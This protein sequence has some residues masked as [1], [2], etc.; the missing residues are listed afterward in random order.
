MEMPC[1]RYTT[2]DLFLHRYQQVTLFGNDDLEMHFN[3]I[4]IQNPT[5]QILS[6]DKRTFELTDGS[7]KLGHLTYEN[8]FSFKAN[9]IVGSDKYEIT[10]T[11]IFSS[12]ISVTKNGIEVANL[13]MNWKGHITILFPHGQEFILK[14]TGIFMDDYALEDKDRQILMFL[15]PDFNWSKFVYNYSISYANKPQDLLLVLLATY[16]ANYCITAASAS[17]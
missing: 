16:A 12:S 17:C 15:D 7:D 2:A 4:S 5:M 8:L 13:N 1:D 14:A 3:E 11:G 9:A 10:P 6:T